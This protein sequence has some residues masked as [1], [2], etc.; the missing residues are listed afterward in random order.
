MHYRSPEFIE[1]GQ[2]G[3]L[4]LLEVQLP[5]AGQALAVGMNDS[6]TL[7]VDLRELS[8]ER[9][10]KLLH[11]NWRMLQSLQSMAQI[12][13][14]L[15]NMEEQGHICLVNVHAAF[16]NSRPDV[17]KTFGE[18]KTLF[19]NLVN[20]RG[21]FQDNKF[22]IDQSVALCG[23][24]DGPC[25]V[26]VGNFHGANRIVVKDFWDMTDNQALRFATLTDT[27]YPSYSLCIASLVTLVNFCSNAYR[28]DQSIEK[29]LQRQVF[30]F[31]NAAESRVVVRSYF[32]DMYML[33]T[34]DAGRRLLHNA[35]NWVKSPLVT[36]NERWLMLLSAVFLPDNISTRDY[37]VHDRVRALVI[38][39]PRLFS[40]EELRH[41]YPTI[42]KARSCLLLEYLNQNSASLLLYGLSSAGEA[43]GVLRLKLMGSLV[44]ILQNLYQT[45]NVD[46]LLSMSDI[47]YLMHSGGVLAVTA[48]SHLFES[49]LFHIFSGDDVSSQLRLLI[50]SNLKQIIKAAPR[51]FE[52]L[53][54]R[55][56]WKVYYSHTLT[57][58]DEVTTQALARMQS[59]MSPV[60]QPEAFAT[61]MLQFIS[62]HTS[63]K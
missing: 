43:A 27:V 36:I 7:D 12:R 20:S 59:S 16:L 45:T 54:S 50:K 63:C 44:W 21:P 8:F 6:T 3:P 58:V 62:H 35:I 39:N 49:E 2:Y 41:Q 28:Q 47:A 15:E 57:T 56:A 19:W 18:S 17:T 32:H 37:S 34:A 11:K 53:V 48:T 55:S 25:S 33:S 30:R 31:R 26:R 52:K 46:A 23:L 10:T 13:H 29:L 24:F 61:T 51:Q 40:N 1:Q 38:I 14:W 42:Y 5:P 60:R 9:R 4:T 22:I